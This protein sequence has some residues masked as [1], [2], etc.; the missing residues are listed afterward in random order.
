[1]DAKCIPDRNWVNTAVIKLREEPNAILAGSYRVS[2]QSNSVKDLVYGMLYLQN[3]KNIEMSYG[4]TAGNMAT[5]KTTFTTIG[6]FDTTVGTGHDIEWS[7]KAILHEEIKVLYEPL[8]LVQYNGQSFSELCS[9]M[10]KYALGIFSL[11]DKCHSAFNI[12]LKT[13]LR[14][15]LPMRVSTF[16]KALS[17][18]SLYA[19]PTYKKWYLYFLVWSMKFRLSLYYCKFF[20]NLNSRKLYPENPISA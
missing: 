10:N 1:M 19:V 7:K 4:V 5:T 9:K 2:P 13:I 8:L 18:R 14:N 12:H 11:N 17:Y 6:Q 15:L 3:Q 20:L 16:R